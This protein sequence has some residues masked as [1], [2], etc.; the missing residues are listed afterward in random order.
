MEATFSFTDVGVV[1]E[2]LVIIGSG[3]VAHKRNNRVR[4]GCTVIR[5]EFQVGSPRT[6]V[7]CVEIT[8]TTGPQ[9]CYHPTCDD[10]LRLAAETCQTRRLGVALTASFVGGV[11]EGV[12]RAEEDLA[13]APCTARGTDAS[14]V[15]ALACL[16]GYREERFLRRL[17]RS[18]LAC[19]NSSA[20]GGMGIPAGLRPCVP[21]LSKNSS[22]ASWS[23]DVRRGRGKSP[24]N[25]G[26]PP[27][28]A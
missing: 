26:E 22:L 23:R 18:V 6:S 28:A 25:N 7:V 12:S 24:G 27:V 19:S 15:A 1:S 14:L 3:A 11:K 21:M 8:R 20:G 4:V 9:V 2:D 17:A 16:P 10:P 5:H 13:E